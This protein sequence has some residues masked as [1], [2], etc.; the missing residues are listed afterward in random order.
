VPQQR[1]QIAEFR[2][3]HPD[4]REAIFRQQ[5]QEQYRVSTIVFLA[6]GFDL[7]NLRGI[8]DPGT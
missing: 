6:A 5:V 2:R 8:A 3:R 7:S 4:R 1:A